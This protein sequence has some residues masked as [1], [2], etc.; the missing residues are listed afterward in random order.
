MTEPLKPCPFCGSETV[1]LDEWSENKHAVV[2]CLDC[3]AQGPVADADIYVGEEQLEK[4]A[5]FLWNERAFLEPV[6]GSTP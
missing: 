6:D 5:V 4:A 2:V 3:D 1:D